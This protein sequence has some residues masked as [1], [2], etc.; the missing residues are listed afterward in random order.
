MSSLRLEPL[1]PGGGF[2]FADETKGGVVPREYIPAVE[3]GA[4]E[5]PRAACS[6]AIRWST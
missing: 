3:K 2:E 1:P 4:Q 6:P 5:A